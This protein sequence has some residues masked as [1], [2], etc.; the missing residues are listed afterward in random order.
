MFS[1]MLSHSLS[2]VCNFFLFFVFP[3]FSISLVC[4]MALVSFYGSCSRLIHRGVLVFFF[5]V[6]GNWTLTPVK[7][8]FV[9]TILCWIDYN[10]DQ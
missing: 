1:S 7:S 10:N 6:S 4:A 2:P 5:C 3:Q 9:D 8:W